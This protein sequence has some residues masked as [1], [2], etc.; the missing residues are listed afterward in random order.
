LGT[1]WEP[2]LDISRP[3]PCPGCGGRLRLPQ[4]VPLG[5]SVHPL[6]C[7]AISQGVTPVVL[8]GRFLKN[9]TD[10][11][12]LWLPGVKY[13]WGEKNGDLDIL[14]SCDG[15][16]VVAECKTHEQTEEG[17]GLWEKTLEQFAGT[18]K[19]GKACGAGIA[20]L[21]VM[22]KSF[23]AGFQQRAEELAGPRMKCLLLNREDLE[24]GRRPTPVTASNPFGLLSLADLMP[25]EA[26]G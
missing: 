9:L 25:D 8:A 22:A 6:I 10:R 7:H 23:P 26:S 2:G 4:Q 1:Y 5:Y 17:D 13:T 15:V 3:V 21:A 11:G 16:V 19:V 18:V 24:R 12:F 14:A 20:V